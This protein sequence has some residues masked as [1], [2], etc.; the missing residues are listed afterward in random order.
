MLFR[1]AILLL[2]SCIAHSHKGYFR[3]TTMRPICFVEEVGYGVDV[4]R[5]GYN[6]IDPEGETKHSNTEGLASMSEANN[7]SPFMIKIANPKGAVLFTRNIGD[8]KGS[9]LYKIEDGQKLFGEYVICVESEKTN[10]KPI[11][12]QISIDHRNKERP[13]SPIPN[14]TTVKGTG[15]NGMA[16]QTFTDS[17]GNT[18]EVLKTQEELRRMHQGLLDVQSSMKDVKRESKYF[19]ERQARFVM[20]TDSTHDRVWGTSVVTIAILII[21]SV[22]QYFHLK[23][24]LL[25]KKMV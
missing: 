15:P 25:Q 12:L 9:V 2:V 11:K 6:V 14:R 17:A 7:I 5:V 21:T 13:Q 4:V 16:I 8:S 22:Y 20:T 19:S 10:K 24:F 18:K 1:L 3:L 23:N